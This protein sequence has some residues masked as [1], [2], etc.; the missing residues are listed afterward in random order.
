MICDKIRYETNESAIASIV[1]LSKRFKQRFKVYRCKDCGCFHVST[2]KKQKT[3]TRKIKLDAE[4]IVYTKPIKK[5]MP[6]SI[7]NPQPNCMVL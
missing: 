5:Y 7:K 2:I 3:D 4:E 1:A 6:V